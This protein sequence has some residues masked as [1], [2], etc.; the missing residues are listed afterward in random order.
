MKNPARTRTC[1]CCRVKMDKS[2]MIRV[3]RVNGGYVVDAEGKKDGRG[4]YFCGK[5]ECARKLFKTR[6]LNRS[7]KESVP[8]KIYDELIQ[9]KGE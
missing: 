1:V 9:E 2:L 8:E 6:A 4:A 5:E 7:F 3:A